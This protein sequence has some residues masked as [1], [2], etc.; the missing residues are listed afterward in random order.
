MKY[1]YK[2]ILTFLLLILGMLIIALLI[3]IIPIMP[4]GRFY[5]KMNASSGT[6]Y[7][8]FKDG[9]VKFVTPHGESK[10]EGFDVRQLGIYMKSGNRWL[11]ISNGE[12]NI[13]LT[14]ILSVEIIQLD[15]NGLATGRIKFP[16]MFWYK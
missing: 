15:K 5:D 1:K 3:G 2:Y 13:I 6:V 14:T 10:I 12:T 9:T 7:F 8:E 16:R 4:G 11:Y